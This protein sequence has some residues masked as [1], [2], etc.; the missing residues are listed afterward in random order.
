MNP[1]PKTPTMTR[2]HFEYLARVLNEVDCGGEV[3]SFTWLVSVFEMHLRD[4]N[5]RFDGARF[6]EAATRNRP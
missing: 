6:I 4:T 2:Q 5:P 1:W 3:V